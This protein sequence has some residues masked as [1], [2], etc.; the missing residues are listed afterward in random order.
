MMNRKTFLKLL[1]AATAVG[2]NGLEAFAR[3]GPRPQFG[4]WMG[5]NYKTAEEWKRAFERMRKAGI[6][7]VLPNT[8]HEKLATLDMIVPAARNEGIDV[9]VWR[10]AMLNTGPLQEHPEWYG[11]SRSGHSTAVKPPYVDYYR[12]LCP[13]R[14][15]VQQYLRAQIRQLADVP[16]I[17]SVH[18]DYIRFPDVIL[19]VG[20]W[21][22]YHL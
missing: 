12:F 14:P 2:V 10:V 15:E 17:K 16:G 19:P 20:L 8:P 18:L 6:T 4:M 5:N 9:H 3:P 1:G 22:K 7:M 13:N 21:S 11:V